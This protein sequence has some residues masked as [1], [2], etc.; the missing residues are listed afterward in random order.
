[1]MTQVNENNLKEE[2][3]LNELLEVFI[4]EVEK[5]LGLKLIFKEKG[6]DTVGEYQVISP[7]GVKSCQ[8]GVFWSSKEEKFSIGRETY[9]F[10]YSQVSQ[11]AWDAITF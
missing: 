2:I 1:M 8:L 5:Q 7:A 11:D 3:A 6:V 4:A 10:D 9:S